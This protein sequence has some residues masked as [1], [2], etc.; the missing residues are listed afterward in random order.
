VDHRNDFFRQS[1][2]RLV[3]SALAALLSACV[4]SNPRSAPV[5]WIRLRPSSQISRLCRRAKRRRLPGRPT[6]SPRRWW[7]TDLAAYEPIDAAVRADDQPPGRSGISHRGHAV[8]FSVRSQMRPVTSPI[9]PIRAPRRSERRRPTPPGLVPAGLTASASSSSQINLAGAPRPTIVG[10]TGYKV[11]ETGAFWRRPPPLPMRT[12]ASP[13][14]R[15]TA[16]RVGYDRG[17]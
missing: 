9:R 6:S 1:T 3:A 7:S 13:P 15:P 10:V 5:T 17:Q 11:S 8:P 4:R 12:L 16:T 14:R 2:A